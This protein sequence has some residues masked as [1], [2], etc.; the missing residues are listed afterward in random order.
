MNVFASRGDVIAVPIDNCWAL[1]RVLFV[2][3]HF[4]DIMLVEFYGPFSSSSENWKN[5]EKLLSVYT[6]ATKFEKRGWKTVG[7][8]EVADSELKK[9]IRVVADEVWEQ[10]RFLR[11]ASS[12]DKKQIPMMLVDGFIRVETKLK[13]L[14]DKKRVP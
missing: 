4:K 14:F 13:R 12:S 1:G 6:A 2:S 7:A 11:K 8:T 3:E 9:T 10:D 5:G